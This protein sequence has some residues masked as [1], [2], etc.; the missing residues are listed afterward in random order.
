MKGRAH[1][2]FSLYGN[3]SRLSLIIAKA[4]A[5]SPGFDTKPRFVCVIA[6]SLDQ[7][8]FLYFGE[9][10]AN[11]NDRVTWYKN[12]TLVHSGTLVR[13]DD[14]NALPFFRLAVEF[15]ST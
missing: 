5:M 7:I 11:V 6:E 2:A 3:P 8:H 12:G 4:A 15:S 1:R 13:T 10:L 14:E 9:R